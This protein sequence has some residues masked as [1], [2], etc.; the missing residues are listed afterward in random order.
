MGRLP[1]AKLYGPSP[2][3][4]LASEPVQ[5]LGARTWGERVTIELQREENYALRKAGFR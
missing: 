5:D 3:D 2:A 4:R 1:I